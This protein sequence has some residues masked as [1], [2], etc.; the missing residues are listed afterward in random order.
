MRLGYD[1]CD[2]LAISKLLIVSCKMSD[3]P[4]LRDSGGESGERE[5]DSESNSSGETHA[6]TLDA[7]GEQP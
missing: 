7:P 5:D 4:P 3:V 2:P 1:R 6:G